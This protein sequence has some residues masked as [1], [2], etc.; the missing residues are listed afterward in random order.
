MNT[1]M[2]IE[3]SCLAISAFA[4]AN[5][6][7]ELTAVEYMVKYYNQLSRRERTALSV[8]MDYTKSVDNKVI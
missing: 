1:I 2:G 4:Q 3:E 7:D 6:V 8:F 5:H